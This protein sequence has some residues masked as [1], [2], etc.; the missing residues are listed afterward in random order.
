MFAG[1]LIG[2]V[3]IFKLGV[4]AALIAAALTFAIVSAWAWRLKQTATLAQ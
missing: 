2:G 4:P 1:A 3:L